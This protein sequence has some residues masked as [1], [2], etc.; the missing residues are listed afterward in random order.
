L[1]LF[2]IWD[3]EIGVFRKMK[4]FP[5]ITAVIFYELLLFAVS[6]YIWHHQDFFDMPQNTAAVQLTQLLTTVPE[7]KPRA[8]W[9]EIAH[10]YSIPW[11]FKAEVPFTP[12]APF[13]E[14][15]DPWQ[16]FC[17]EAVILMLTKYYKSPSP[18][19]IISK[20]EASGLMLYIMSQEEK[21]LGYHKN[22]GAEDIA[23]MLKSVFE[24]EA[25]VIEGAS[26]E[27]IK[28][29]ILRYR[30]VI[31]PAAGRRLGNPYFQKGRPFYHTIIVI[32][33]DDSDRTFIVH[34][35]GTR[36]GKEYKYAQQTLFDAMADWSHEEQK[37]I[38]RKVIVVIE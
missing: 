36:F 37:V 34:E 26:I 10:E 20:N 12:Q 30:P 23:Q 17:E 13:G 28:E 21:L 18:T 14:W 27:K 22:T 32:G 11:A 19:T 5:K 35:P 7:V 9:K 1:N 8:V 29:E 4:L 15:N 24:L 33:Y 38:D 3:F 16:D 25:K 6:Y 31:I 2:G